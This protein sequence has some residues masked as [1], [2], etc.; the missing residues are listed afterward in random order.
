MEFVIIPRSAQ[1]QVA[2]DELGLALVAVVAETRLVVST[3]M[4]RQFLSDRFGMGREDAYV[5]RHDPEDF[6]V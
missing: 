2:V 1:L 4:V 3:A 5:H 6:V